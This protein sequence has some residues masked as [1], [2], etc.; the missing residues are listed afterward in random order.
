MA[1][2]SKLRYLV[3]PYVRK[4][5]EKFY[6]GHILAEKPLPLRKE[7]DGTYAFHN[8]VVIYGKALM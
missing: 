2:T 7:K 6:P 3:E 4:E 1:D 5:L 8:K